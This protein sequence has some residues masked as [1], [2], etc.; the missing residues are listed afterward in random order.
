MIGL[1]Q[2]SNNSSNIVPYLRRREAMSASRRDK[3]RYQVAVD[4]SRLG[5]FK[6]EIQRLGM[7]EFTG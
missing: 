6:D 4:A 2:H 7:Y 1:T 3:Y 5:G